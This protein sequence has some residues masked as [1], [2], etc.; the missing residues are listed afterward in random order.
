MSQTRVREN[1]RVKAFR[2]EIEA[3]RNMDKSIPMDSD[4][5]LATLLRL[6]QNLSKELKQEMGFSEEAQAKIKLYLDID[7]QILKHSEYLIRVQKETA[8]DES[9]IKNA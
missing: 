7:A 6:K 2:H 9:A 1:R 4:H 8:K 3:Y 5:P